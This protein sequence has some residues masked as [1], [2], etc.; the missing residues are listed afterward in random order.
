METS[1]VVFLAFVGASITVCIYSLAQYIKSRKLPSMT[2]T[3]KELHQHL[4][5]Y[6]G[7]TMGHLLFLNDKSFFWNEEKTVL[8]AFRKV[9]RKLIVF[10]DPIGKEQEIADSLLQFKRWAETYKCTPIFYQVNPTFLSCYH[11]LG[12][13]FYKLGEE[14]KVNLQQYSIAGK[15]GARLRTRRNKFLRNGYEFKVIYPPYNNKLLSELKLVSDSWLNGRKEKSFSVSFFDED[16]VSRFPIALLKG[17]DHSIIAFATLAIGHEVT[18]KTMTIDLM[19]HI[20]N[21]PHGTMDMLFVSI[22]IWAKEKGLEWCSLGMSPLA[23]VGTNR[24]GFVSEKIGRFLFLHGNMFYK[25]KGLKEFKDK[26]ACT[27]ESKYLAYKKGLLPM[28]CLQIILVIHQVPG[29]GMTSNKNPR[30]TRQKAS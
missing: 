9:G 11:D 20:A 10:G 22:L 5:R 12:Y 24:Y 16:Y 14:A 6:N 18:G 4:S 19:R 30:K 26:F 17:P 28:I 2:I 3:E 13:K 29:M 1:T 7:S 8:I 25:F 27:W 15:K 21:Q 23:N